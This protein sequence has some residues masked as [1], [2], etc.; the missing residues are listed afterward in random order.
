MC[1]TPYPAGRLAQQV[2]S[3]TGVVP[4]IV[5]NYSSDILSGQGLL[6]YLHIT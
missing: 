6:L 1:A 4:K 3:L 5:N 2:W